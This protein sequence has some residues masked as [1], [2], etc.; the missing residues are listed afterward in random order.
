M[1]CIKSLTSLA[2]CSAKLFK[3]KLEVSIKT[4]IINSIF[5]IPN[6][7]VLK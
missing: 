2:K 6:K 3:L 5:N 1:L 7:R 4:T